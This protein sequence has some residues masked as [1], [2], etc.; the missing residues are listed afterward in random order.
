MAVLKTL[1]FGKNAA[2]PLIIFCTRQQRMRFTTTFLWP[3][4]V[5]RVYHACRRHKHELFQDLRWDVALVERRYEMMGQSQPFWRKSTCHF[6]TRWRQSFCFGKNCWHEKMA[7]KKHS[8]V[9]NLISFSSFFK[10]CVCWFQTFWRYWIK[11]I[12]LR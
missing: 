9:E 1:I 4:R 11:S 7:R 10:V 3:R 12:D 5:G 2:G 8:Y 6:S